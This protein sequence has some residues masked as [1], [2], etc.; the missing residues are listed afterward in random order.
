MRS[1]AT[2]DEL[3]RSYLLGELTEEETDEVERRLLTE[4]ELFELSEAV[5]A[6]LLAACARNELAPAES[7]RVLQRLAWSA[8]GRERLALARSLNTVADGRMAPVIPFPR[9]VIRWAALAA[10]VLLAVVGLFWFAIE[11]SGHHDQEAAIQKQHHPTPTPPAPPRPSPPAPPPVPVGP[12]PEPVKA[13]FQLALTALRGSESAAK[14][15][16]IPADTGV[17]ELQIS[18]EEL[19]DLASFHLTLRNRQSEIVR[20]KSGLKPKTL[21]GV[22]VVVLDVPA[23]RLPAGRY[24]LQ[25]QGTAPGSEPEDLSPLEIE[26]VSNERG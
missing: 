11:Q 2:D 21:G 13:V 4:D 26:V 14:Q 8:Q 9:P 3:L 7:K 23:D 12:A 1:N 5:E 10:A 20:D 15:L 17:V 6:D 24:E 25:A 22:R 16:S 19:Q 18:V